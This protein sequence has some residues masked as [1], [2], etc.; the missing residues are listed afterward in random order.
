MAAMALCWAV[1]AGS[2]AA[3]TPDTL[4]EKVGEWEIRCDMPIGAPQEVCAMLQIVHAEDRQNLSMAVAVR[5]AVVQVGDQMQQVDSMRIRT[6]LGVL[7]PYGIGLLVDGEDSGRVPFVRCV[8]GSC[9]SELVLTP[10]LV[11]KLKAGN[12]AALIVW[13]TQEA[14]IGVPFSLSGFSQAYDKLK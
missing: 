10:P 9:I 2:A 6:P 5:K 13:Q 14:G 7:L 4:R 3:Q 12:T 11:A 8:P 1:A